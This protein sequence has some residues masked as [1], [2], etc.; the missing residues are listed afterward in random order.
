M[1]DS[2]TSSQLIRAFTQTRHNMQL[3]ADKKRF[4]DF[5]EV[6]KSRAK[7]LKGNSKD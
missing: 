2:K 5:Q 7:K 4:S 3:S 6:I 1:T